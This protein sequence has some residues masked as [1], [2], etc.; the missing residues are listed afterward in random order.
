MKIMGIDASTSAIGYGIFEKEKLIVSGVIKPKHSN[1]WTKRIEEEWKE[2]NNLV[3][4]YKP[5]LLYIE[6]VPLKKGSFTLQ[7]LG[8]VQGMI[9]SI[10]AQHNIQSVF[11]LPS[12]WRKAVG[13]Y[14]GTR[15]GLQRDVLKKKAIELANEL[16]NLNLKWISPTSTLN[17]DDEAEGILIAWSQLIP[18]KGE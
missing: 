1:N 14:D 2:L 18:K 13:I 16:F 17:E 7:K 9:L 6:Q 15:N 3:K 4:K 10:C 5:R 11:L 12:E 8:A